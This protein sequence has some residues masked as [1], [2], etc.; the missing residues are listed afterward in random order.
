MFTPQRKPWPVLTT[1]QRTGGGDSAAKRKG[2][3]VVI[4]DAVAAPPVNTLSGGSGVLTAE[5]VNMED[6]MRFKEAGLLDV[7]NMERKD[8]EALVER[9][10]A[11][12]AE[13]TDYQHEMGRLLIEQKKMTSNCDD[14]GKAL[15]EVQ[16]ILKREKSAHFIALSEVEKREENLRQA[17]IVEKRRQA[18]EAT[19]YK[20]RE[21]LREWEKKLQQGEEGLTELR[22]NINQREEKANENDKLLKQRE[23][24]LEEVQKRVDLS[25]SKLREKEDLINNRLAD[26]TSKEKEADYVRSM[27]EMKKMELQGLEEKLSAREKKE[28]QELLDE[29]RIILDA[30]LQEFE[31]EMEEKRKSVNEELRSKVESIEQRE[32]EVNHK[33]EKLTKRE[34]ALDNKLER[35][36]DKE[37]D[38]D[39]RLKIAKEEEKVMKSEAKNLEVEKQKLLADKQNLDTL[40]SEIDNIRDEITRQELSIREEREKLKVTK[41]ERVEH[42]RLQSELKQQLENCRSQEGLLLKQREELREEKERFEKEWEILDEKKVE[43]ARLENKIA[44]EKRK[45]EKFQQ[46]EQERLKNEE[47]AIQVYIQREMEAI[48]KQ[49]ESFEATMKYEKS[50]LSEK[51]QNDRNQMIQEFE[52]QKTSFEAELQNK[53]DEME[54]LLRDREREFEE[55]KDQ[56]LKYA[57]NLKEVAEREMEQTKSERAKLERERQTVVMDKKELESQQ[58]GMRQDIVELDGLTSK[59]KNQREQ[60]IHEKKRFLS[61]VEKH[62]NCQNCGEITR[63]FVLTDLQ[64]PEE[65]GLDISTPDDI[66]IKKSGG[67]SDSEV[68]ISWLRKCTSKIFSPNKKSENFTPLALTEEISENPEN[69]IN[70]PPVIPEDNPQP[71]SMGGNN[72]IDDHSYMPEKSQEEVEVSQQLK[73]KRRGRNPK[74]NR[75]RSVKAVAENDE[76]LL[77][78]KAKEPEMSAS[79]QP[80]SNEDSYGIS[81]LSKRET[82]N[83]ARK[84]HRGQTSKVAESEQNTVD[85]SEVQSESVTAGGGRKKR[86]QTQT[87]APPLQTPGQKRYNLRGGDRTS[88]RV[89][90]AQAKSDI[91]KTD[92]HEADGADLLGIAGPATRQPVPV[93][94]E[95]APCENNKS[96][97]QL[98]EV[99]TIKT[100]EEISQARIVDEISQERN[101]MLETVADIVDDNAD[102]ARSTG[103]VDDAELGRATEI[104]EEVNGTPEYDNEDEN[105]STIYEEEEEE[106][107]SDGEQLQ[108]GEKSITKKIWTFFTT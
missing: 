32:T 35:V 90:A 17:L 54:K 28:I 79:L 8:H 4:G 97:S 60:F 7:A 63:E 69:T 13:L 16:E 107:D 86:R 61:F 12:E 70:N 67:P 75:A 94:S 108:P 85:D 103:L 45:I 99:T 44:E 3:G 56:E 93:F 91:K 47:S 6:W 52:L 83:T 95:A 48:K 72:T 43:I 5:D 92:E 14:L 68:P 46:T 65:D 21:D 98:V 100:V 64:L 53:Q 19:F 15:E 51:A 31:S 105:G 62:K 102:V 87:V 41:A 27:L 34:Q 39:S 25:S 30:K 82:G 59:L 26:L 66:N 2:K 11:L 71:S 57:R 84:R 20:H 23:R 1:P 40:K 38:L 96:T 36:K 76:L 104:S 78:K 10:Y 37:K 89:T 33:L 22:R 80:N 42:L 81:S 88:G 106:E 49:K 50:M 58:L 9:V 18:H 29:Q 101:A 73:P 24:D 55:K 77:G 74:V